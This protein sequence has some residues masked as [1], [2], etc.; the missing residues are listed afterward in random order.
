M[1]DYIK[2]DRTT[3][4]GRSRARRKEIRANNRLMKQ[5]TCL[6]MSCVVLLTT[7]FGNASISFAGKKDETINRIMEQ[8]ESGDISRDEARRALIRNGVKSSP[9]FDFDEDEDGNAIATSS[10]LAR[11]LGEA[12]HIIDEQIEKAI[13]STR[14]SLSSLV[15]AWH[16]DNVDRILDEISDVATESELKKDKIASDSELKKTGEDLT[17]K[18]EKI[19][20]GA[21]K[22]ASSSEI[23]K[24]ENA[25]EANAESETTEVRKFSDEAESSESAK[26]ISD[27]EESGEESKVAE[28]SEDVNSDAESSEDQIDLTEYLTVSSAV[29]KYHDEWIESENFD[30][31]SK[32]GLTLNFSIPEDVMFDDTTN[33]A[34][35][36][37]PDGLS[38]IYKSTGS[39]QSGDDSVGTYKVEKDEITITFDKSFVK[40]GKAI[41]GVLFFKALVE[42]KTDD[43]CLTIDLGGTAGS[44]NVYKEVR[45]YAI[46]DDRKVIVTATYGAST[47]E[48]DVTLHAESLDE[49]TSADVEDAFN[50]KLKEE[51]LKVS[52]M[53]VYDVFFL[54]EEGNKIEPDGLVSVKMTFNHP[55]EKEDDSELKVFH[56]KNND[57]SDIEDLT[58]MEDTV[59][60]E[61]SKGM[62]NNV[63]LVTDSFSIMALANTKASVKPTKSI[64]ISSY[65]SDINLSIDGNPVKLSDGDTWVI[66]SKT[67]TYTFDVTFSETN[68]HQFETIDHDVWMSY[69]LPDGL[70][71][72]DTKEDHAF[73]MSVAGGKTIVGNKYKIVDNVIYFNWTEDENDFVTINSSPNVSFKATINAQ[74]NFSGNSKTIKFSD[75]TERTVVLD[76]DIKVTKKGE[77]D[78]SNKWINYTITIKSVGISYDVNVND[79]LTG[80]FL[81]LDSSSIKVESKVDGKSSEKDL[82]ELN[83]TS[84]DKSF[85][86]TIGKM[87]DDEKV[88]IT[89]HTEP[90][91]LGSNKDI[92]YNQN[93]NT[94][95]VTTRDNPDGKTASKNIHFYD[96]VDKSV[97][98]T[99]KIIEE[100][101]HRYKIIPW[102]IE[103]NKNHAQNLSFVK[104][105]IA[106]NSQAYMSYYGD[107]L[108]IRVNDLNDNTVEER[109][110][111][112]NSS[113]LNKSHNSK[114][115][116]I[117]WKLSIPDKYKNYYYKITYK[118]KVA[119]DDLCDP[120]FKVVNT[121]EISNG[122]TSKKEYKVGDTAH[123]KKALEASSEDITWEIKVKV[124]ANISYSTF[125]IKDTLPYGQFNNEFYSDS[126]DKVISITD[127]SGKDISN[128]CSVTT[129]TSNEGKHYVQ[130]DFQKNI[131]S[132]A[133]RYII[134]RYKTKNNAD[135]MKRAIELNQ[136]QEGDINR[137]TNRATIKT[138]DYKAEVSDQICPP[139]PPTKELKKDS[140]LGSVKI[141]KEKYILITYI[142]SLTNVSDDDF[143]NGPLT[144]Y[145][146]FDPNL[147]LCPYI[148]NNGY[149]NGYNGR[150][151]YV[152]ENY[153]VIDSQDKVNIDSLSSNKIKLTATS[154]P[155]NNGN[156]Y[157]EYRITYFLVCKKSDANNLAL[158]NTEEPGYYSF[159]NTA[160]WGDATATVETKHTY[161]PVSK[162]YQ[163]KDN[164]MA[165]YT[166]TVNPNMDDLLGGAM[167]TL[168]D[169]Y[170]NLVP[171]KNSIV[172]STEDSKGPCDNSIS[173]S[174][175]E[176]NHTIIFTNIPDKTTVVIDYDCMPVFK[177]KNVQIKNTVNLEGYTD[178]VTRWVTF[179]STTSGSLGLAWLNL[180]KVDE[181][182]GELLNDAKFELYQVEVDANGDD[183][184][185][186]HG[187]PKLT[188]V[189]ATKGETK[190]ETITFTTQTINGINGTAQIAI[191]TNDTGVT[192][193]DDTKYCLVESECPDGYTLNQNNRYYF[194]ITL[195]KDNDPS[196]KV[197]DDPDNNIYHTGSTITIT[198]KKY[199]AFAL[200]DTGNMGV[201]IIYMVGSLMITIGGFILIIMRKR[202]DL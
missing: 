184:L 149:V 138:S 173:A 131:T 52:D 36:T 6:S 69:P 164:N 194:T 181:D 5:L 59:I 119:I 139:Y 198:N 183:I 17:A 23:L 191:N 97:D 7:V 122:D 147:S 109:T 99:P 58:S 15:F 77:Y 175:D 166:I 21:A 172:I 106:E 105:T 42:N 185:D 57:L 1:R 168:T 84:D 73:T 103:I 151:S 121:A 110:I 167:M 155:K 104:D 192:L 162:R 200:P 49:A 150:I 63:E 180:K 170:E 53:L 179:T 98:G 158:Y 146:Q 34:V 156:Y 32:I 31:G 40:S 41:E 78:P 189:I 161:N 123:T 71:V 108:N 66:N 132:G 19:I 176:E 188:P 89:Y 157:S 169:T 124:P 178:S 117:G 2:S 190:G 163:E 13:E 83:L 70:A 88:T 68:K 141:N 129:S 107:G 186:S 33:K 102:T 133:E 95:K 54:D 64:D 22:V 196:D 28:A 61:N 27:A 148:E 152:G 116:F 60:N 101:G 79:V 160:K 43:D 74:F 127:S 29:K 177:T 195:S 91:V 85:S 47:F 9:I 48:G 76:T 37:L 120:D 87:K 118:T 187:N 199:S 72:D 171:D 137:H 182:T 140:R 45:K 67:K 96:N 4:R 30:T 8:Y 193:L 90:F 10:D 115:S 51:E 80:D 56:V 112:W 94:V 144:I 16:H 50:E 26:N 25:D 44:I 14:D 153:Q 113:E 100:D 202:I 145:D 136:P 38:S 159:K 11:K 3:V 135:W 39:I 12:D 154:L 174:L 130:F 197:Y 20:E 143:K 18:V 92:N 46:S 65:V 125:Y 111:A 81:K 128:L 201:N 24:D 35:Y 75:S 55:I 165:H 134:I 114:E 86:L 82:S 93:N 142:L 62:V 126:F